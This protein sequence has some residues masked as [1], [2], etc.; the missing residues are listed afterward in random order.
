MAP[1]PIGSGSIAG[2]C[3]EGVDLLQLRNPHAK[4][5]WR[6]AWSDGDGA[7]AAHPA[8]RAELQVSGKDDGTFWMSKED[9]C[10]RA[11][12]IWMCVLPEGLESERA[13]D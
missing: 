4:G 7:W 8:I 6:G 1:S 12:S 2:P 13:S 11:D 3:G 9:F 10:E 5:E